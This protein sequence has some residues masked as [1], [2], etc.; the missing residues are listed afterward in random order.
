MNHCLMIV[1]N[2]L[3][4]TKNSVESLMN[5]TIPVK[6]WVINENSTDGTA[7]WL[8]RNLS[9]NLEASHFKPQHTCLSEAWNYGLNRLFRQTDSGVDVNNDTLFS[10]DTFER[11][12]GYQLET[13]RH[14]VS[15][16]SSDRPLTRNFR[17]GGEGEAAPGLE[18]FPH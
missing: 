8:D 7:V 15:G 13:G 3:H 1:R 16:V 10:P 6:V 9:E 18:L 14:F 11:L 4:F 2:C 5:Q 12:M 17:K